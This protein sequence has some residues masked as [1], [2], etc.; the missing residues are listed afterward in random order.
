MRNPEYNLF[1]GK[2][3]QCYFNLTAA[4]HEIILQSEGYKTKEGALN[5]IKSVQENCQDDSKYERKIAVNDEPYFVLKANNGESI[6]RSETYSSK[7][8]MEKG[9]AS[10]KKNGTTTIIDDQK[11]E[12]INIFINKEKYRTQ[13]TSRTGSEI[14]EIASLSSSEYSLYLIKGSQKE[15]ILAEQSVKLKNGMHF[16]AILKDITFG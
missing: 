16:H 4:N 13:A 5:G 3:G 10:V 11:N 8:A 1:T 14:L 12:T 6:G 7:Q 9:I 2:D 15:E